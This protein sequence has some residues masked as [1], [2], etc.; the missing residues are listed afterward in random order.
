M[1]T[2]VTVEMMV[3]LAEKALLRSVVERAVTATV[4][5]AG[6][7]RGAVKT[8]VAPLAVCDGE[9]DPQLGALLH[10]AT[11]STPALATSLDTVAE[12]CA[13]L[14]TSKEEGGAWVMATEM[15]G[16]CESFVVFA[17]HPAMPR[18]A[19][20]PTTNGR[21]AQ[22]QRLQGEC[23]FIRPPVSRVF[24]IAPIRSKQADFPSLRCKQFIIPSRPFPYEFRFAAGG[25][26]HAA[27]SRT[28]IL[29]D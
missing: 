26:T 19:V 13:L 27:K 23:C 21:N 3:T 2:P 20:R 16:V 6:T 9:K 24:S 12:T 29:D 14:P 10:I 7:E 25:P 5:F 8:V 15:R 22:K 4:F 28:L 18:K 1:V 17:E 11:Q